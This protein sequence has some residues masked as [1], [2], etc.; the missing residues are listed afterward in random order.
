MPLTALLMFTVFMVTIQQTGCNSSLQGN[1]AFSGTDS[2]WRN[3]WLCFNTLAMPPIDSLYIRY[4]FVS[5]SINNN[6]E[7]WIIDNMDARTLK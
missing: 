7:G 4:R 3:I 1:T 2:L 6:R 5:D